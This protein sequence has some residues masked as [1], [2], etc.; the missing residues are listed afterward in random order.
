M[1]PSP[2]WTV[3]KKAAVLKQLK[4][5]QQQQG[6]MLLW[7]SHQMEDLCLYCQEIVWLKQ[8]QLQQQQQLWPLQQGQTFYA[9]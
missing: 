9:I 7:V 4:H 2:I 3:S 8:G 6:F 5:Y 1:R